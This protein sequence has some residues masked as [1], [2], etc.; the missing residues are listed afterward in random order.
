M[1]LSSLEGKFHIPK[2]VGQ[3]LSAWFFQIIRKYSALQRLKHREKNVESTE[4]HPT[5]RQQ[6]HTQTQW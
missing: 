6:K 4:K 3:A 1:L 2:A 5:A